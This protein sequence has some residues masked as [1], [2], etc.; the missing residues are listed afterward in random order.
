M[1]INKG[2]KPT[3]TANE[4]ES[5]RL[6]IYNENLYNDFVF[7]MEHFLLYNNN[8]NKFYITPYIKQITLTGALR[9]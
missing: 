2:I 3:S 9:E 7:F 5:N 8:N 4:A 1:Q 6:Y